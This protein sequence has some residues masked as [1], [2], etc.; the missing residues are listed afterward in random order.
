VT[1]SRKGAKSRAHGSK[2]R[3]S[4]TKARTHVGPEPGAELEKKLKAYIR[5]LE[6]KLDTR[7]RELSEAREYLAEALKQQTATSEVLRVISNSPT[8]LQPVLDAVGEYAAR[9][10]DA[11][12]AVIFRLEGDLLR[13]VASYG[14]IP[15]TSH[16]REGLPVNRDTVSGRAV[17]DRRT[18]HVHDLAAED[19]EY[20]LG[21]R[22]AK[23]DGH[24]TTLATPLLREGAPVGAI[25]IRRME[26]RPFSDTQIA[27]LGTFANQASIAIE[28]VRLFEA[29]QQRTRD[30]SEALEQQSATSEVLQVISSSPGDLEPV[31]RA[32][33]TNATRICGA[34]FGV[35]FRFEDGLFH[36]AALLDVPPAF[37]DFLARQGSF[38]PEPGRLFGRLSQTKKV[39]QVDDRATEPDP[40]PSARYGGARS[41]IAVPMLKNNELIGAFF[42]YRTEVRPFTDKQVELVQNFAAQAVIAIENTRLLNELR[43]SLQQQTAT[44]EVLSVI[45]SSPGDLGPVFETMLANATRLCGAEF[46]ILNLD[47][48]DVSRIAAVYNVPPAFAATQNVPFRIHAKSGQAEIRRSK[49]AVHI[50][51]IRAMPPYFEG[52]PR[53]VA[54]A[55]LGGARTTVAVPMLKEDALLGTIT[56]YRQEV[57]PF[58]DKQIELLTNFAAQAV[59]A[60]ENTRL[61]NELRESLQQQTATADVLKVISR[62]TFDL[63]TVLDTLAES[64]ARLCDADHVWL[65]RREGDAYRWAASYGHS[66]EDHERVKQYM[67]TL[68]HSPGR[69]SAVGRAVMGGRPVQITDVLADPEYTQTRAQKLAHYRTLLGAPLLREGVPIGAIALQRTDVRPFTDKQI[70][71]VQTFADQAVIAIEN[72]RLLN[73]LRESLQ[74]QTATADMLKVI[75]RSTFDLQAVLKTLVESAA[76]LCDAYDSAIWRPDGDQLLLVAHHGPIPADTLPLIRGTVAGRTV[77]DGMALH[78]ADLQTEDAEFP[79]SSENARRWAF[80]SIL[81]VPLMRE[82]VAI[83]TIAL[84]RTE[85]Q[86]FTERQVALLQTFADQA[87]IAI[88]NARLFEEVE[89]RTEE[90]SESLQQ[91]TATAD[92]LKVISRSSFDLQTVLDA[93]TA[94]AA[95][96]CEADMAAITRPKGSTFYYATSYGFPADYLEFIRTVPLT[97]GRGSVMGRTLIEGNAVQVHDVLAD[98]EY[99][100]LDHQKKTGARTFLGVPLLR[101]GSPIGVVLL[102][103]STVRP[104]T[105]KQIDLAETFADQAVIAIENVRLFD[106][107]QART[108]EL[109]R[110]VAELR[111]LD[112]VSRA[113]S[114]TLKLETVLETIIGCAVQLSGS[115]SGIVYEFDEVAQ[116]FQARGSHRITAEHLAIVRAEPIRFDEGAVGRAGATQEPVEVA[117][118]ADERQFVAPQTRGLLVREGLRSL[119]AIPLVREQRILG[120]LVI[121]RREAGAFSPE[122]VATLQTFAAQSVLAIQNARLFSEIEDKSH[123]LQLASQHKS[124]FIASMSH[125]LRTPLNAIIGLTE[126]MVTNAARFGTEKALE[127]LRRVNAA[128]THLLSLINEILDLSKI[129]AGKLELN[130]EP[131]DL[132][133]LIDEV[134]GTAG[135]LAEKNKNRLIVQAQ[136]NLGALTSDSMRL[137]QILLNLLSNACKFTKEGEVALRVRKVTDGRDWVELAV[138]DTGIGMTTE[139]QAKLFQE[140]T[141]ADSL[142]ARRYGGTGLGLA[143][144]RKLARMMGGDVTVTSEPG[145]GSDFTL[146]LPS[147][148]EH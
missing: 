24:R 56:I 59:I 88:E 38:A 15:T 142:T 16:P 115:D 116:T 53:L 25:L 147:G 79:E 30:L 20:P 126:M 52:D 11:N 7:T 129:E 112:E 43:E 34:K 83:G 3:S 132:A 119:L 128:G 62:S 31:F 117:D 113:V 122:I 96:L 8:Q 10:C 28:N 9:L 141:Q 26:V 1:L 97:A 92:V 105:D 133:R 42:I 22:H 70:D 103:R 71:L 90:L 23:R 109:A 145:K 86:L 127:P 134:I 47:D 39:I 93:L 101:E 125:E 45:S 17:C 98:P 124:Q 108:H 74:Q 82:G 139:Q 106:E 51:D 110:S 54:L 85:A 114:S 104:F 63:Q 55:D 111:A 27:L 69:G 57:R 48:G 13:Q 66:K 73:E 32:M 64:A 77:L 5:G 89:A 4:G 144:S 121:L 12:N 143:L 75:S 107:V 95:R 2:L 21:S 130:P 60:I 37:A 120:G 44:S 138:A 68:K 148:A 100:Y 140:F 61:L 118:I 80:R 36:P 35:L 40:S 84:R 72:T 33:L 78:I 136:E 91:Q 67:L 76:Q 135:Q 146:R 131:V 46:G 137:K 87:V 14:G 19:S 94:S 65:F 6:E 41:S 49:Q 29:E 81:C 18:I 58:T 99:L 50:D 123:Q 102:A